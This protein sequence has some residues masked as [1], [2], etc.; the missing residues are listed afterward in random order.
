MVAK[1]GDGVL[2]AGLGGDA[3]HLT[4]QEDDHL[5]L[6]AFCLDP[7]RRQ[8]LSRWGRRSTAMM[9]SNLPRQPPAT[10]TSGHQTS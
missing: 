9:Y 7:L 8:S 2:N 5:Q 1:Q 10:T 4:P 3:V 6:A